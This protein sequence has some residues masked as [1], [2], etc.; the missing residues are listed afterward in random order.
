[1]AA[2][3]LTQT[4]RREPAGQ[5]VGVAATARLVTAIVDIFVL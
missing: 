3:A 5:V 4:A 2:A 1:M